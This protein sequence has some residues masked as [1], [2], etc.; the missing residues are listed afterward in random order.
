MKSS[1]VEFVAV[2]TVTAATLVGCGSK[3]NQAS[4]NV[5]LPHVA[6]ESP[7]HDESSAHVGSPQNPDQK[8]EESAKTDSADKGSSGP[9]TA[10]Q[11]LNSADLTQQLEGAREAKQRFSGPESKTEGAP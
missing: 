10:L 9:P 1:I 7:K 3:A 5:A 8:A 4:R 6:A 2:L 11:K